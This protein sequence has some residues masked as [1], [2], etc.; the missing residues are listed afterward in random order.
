MKISIIVPAYNEENRIA[1]T[2]Q[3]INTFF[4]SQNYSYEIIVVDDG[5]KDQTTTVVNNLKLPHTQV[6]SYGGNRGKGYAINFGVKASSGDWILMTDADN[7]TP[8]EQFSK[9]FTQTDQF[10]VIIGSRYMSGSTVTVKQSTPRIVMSRLGNLLVQLLVLPGLFDT[11]CGFKL[12]SASA[13]RAIFPLQTIWGWGFDIEILRIAKEQGYKIKQVPITWRN[14]DQSRIQ[15][16]NV[17]TKTLKEL[18]AIRR[19]SWQGRYHS[20]RS[21][22]GKLVRFA[23]VG[24]IG[25][26]LDYLVLNF[27]HLALG[28]GLYWALTLGFAVGAIHNYILNSV[29]SFRQPL[30][31]T[32]L[33]QFL[34]VA[35]IGLL[36]N[37]GIVFFMTELWGIHYNLAKLVA[38]GIVFFWNYLVNRY[39]TFAEKS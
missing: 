14:D 32:K 36:F 11:Q 25:T 26:T 13:A 15:S 7:S 5:S 22:M 23:I 37:N 20:K 3:I 35:L 28:V 34:C 9:L 1:P 17:F 27:T 10:E 29:W 33:G 6:I 2:L 39:W 4:A 24:A 38:L 12:F 19:N 18:V 16:A 31:L 8:I 30:S 21:E